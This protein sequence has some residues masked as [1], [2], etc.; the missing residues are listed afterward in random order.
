MFRESRILDYVNKRQLLTKSQHGLMKGKSLISPLSRRDFTCV[1][2]RCAAMVATKEYLL[3]VLQSGYIAEICSCDFNK[4]FYYINHDIML[5]KVDY[6]GKQG[7]MYEMVQSGLSCRFEVTVWKDAECKLE[8]V[9]R[10]CHRDLS[11]D[12]FYSCC[13]NDLPM[14]AMAGATCISAK[15][16]CVLKQV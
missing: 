11:C 16:Q 10:G 14:G 6:Y 7:P 9:N 3:E 12:L 13:M 4:T 5:N 8:Q 15:I 2:R 1:A